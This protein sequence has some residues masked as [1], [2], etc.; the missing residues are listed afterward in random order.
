MTGGSYENWRKLGQVAC[1]WPWQ[2]LEIL[3]SCFSNK[4]PLSPQEGR[5][6]LAFLFRKQ[7]CFLLFLY[8]IPASPKFPTL[9]PVTASHQAHA[10]R[11][12][13]SSK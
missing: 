5:W 2:V 13:K 8:T 4:R 6:P 1:E 9:T 12:E 7:G 11:Q 10:V 3:A